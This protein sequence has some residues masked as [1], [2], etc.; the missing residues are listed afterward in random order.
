MTITNEDLYKTIK[1]CKFYQDSITR[2]IYFRPLT[3]GILDTDQKCTDIETILGLNNPRYQ[4]D[5]LRQHYSSRSFD[6]G[7]ASFGDKLY[8]PYGS[9][10][11]QGLFNNIGYKE[12]LVFIFIILA[13]ALF[14]YMIYYVFNK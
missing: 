13:T 7:I 12:I 2:D 5:P 3:K 8:E 10:I 9:V 11:E 1:K 14:I 6:K 4:M